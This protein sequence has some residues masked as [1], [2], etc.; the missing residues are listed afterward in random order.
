MGLEVINWALNPITNGSLR[1][2]DPT[3]TDKDKDE[4]KEWGNKVSLRQTP[5]GNWT[6][7]LGEN[8]VKLALES[9]GY[10]VFRPKKR[11][12]KAPDLET[13]E[14]V[15][16]V[17]TSNWTISGTA[18]EKVLGV[19]YKYATVP[20]LWGKPLI[21]VCVA[22]QEWELTYGNTQ[23]FG[24][25]ISPE[26]K[27]LLDLWKK[28]NLHFVPFSKLVNGSI[29]DLTSY[30]KDEHSKVGGGEETTSW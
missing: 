3:P 30:I 17:K 9:R 26:Q 13:D 10:N 22:Y 19:P 4:E 21:I 20:S 23:I 24:T 28:N 14:F 12:H 8:L 7:Q 5:T 29:K 16:E 2:E 15:V 27:M 25:A 1:R 11:E 18:G 6:S